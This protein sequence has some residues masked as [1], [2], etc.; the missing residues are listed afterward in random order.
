MSDE[1]RFS[2]NGVDAAIRSHP[3]AFD[4]GRRRQTPDEYT[5]AH[6]QRRMAYEAGLKQPEYQPKSDVGG[7]WGEGVS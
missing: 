5:F 2:T 3:Y 4:M 7:W 6:P 1:E